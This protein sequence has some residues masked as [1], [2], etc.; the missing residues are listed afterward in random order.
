MKDTIARS[1]EIIE[2]H[3]RDKLRS[4]DIANSVFVSKYHYQRMF[5]EIMGDSVME[6]VKKRKLSLAGRELIKTDTAILDIAL[7]FGYGSHESFT[8]SFKAYM[9]VTP[10]AYRKY[11]P[12]PIFQKQL[13]RECTNM[14]DRYGK[15]T[16]EIVRDLNGLITQIRQTSDFAL[17]NSP[18]CCVVFWE[19]VVKR[20]NSFADGLNNKLSQ[21][22]AMSRNPDEITKRF[23]MIKIIEDTVFNTNLLAFTVGLYVSRS[24]PENFKIQEPICN[25]FSGLAENSKSKIN[26]IT[27]VFN[28][29]ATLIFEDIKKLTLEKRT[30]AVHVGMN[31]LESLTGYGYIKD[32]VSAIVDELSC[33]S[34]E[35][36]S[37]AYL[38][39]LI[40]RLD[41][42][43]FAASIDIT[44]NPADS[45]MLK[46]LNTFLNCLIETKSIFEDIPMLRETMPGQ[47][48]VEKCFEDIAYQGNILLFYI[49][50]EQEKLCKLLTEDHKARFSAI[51]EKMKVFI[52]IAIESE[53]TYDC[54]GAYSHLV[55]AL[56]EILDLMN[57]EAKALTDK[58]GAIAFIAAEIEK[59]RAKLFFL[60]SQ[61]TKKCADSANELTKRFAANL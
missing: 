10:R 37:P 7:K 58:G 45:A 36:I 1:L 54:N 5:H 22:T 31:A 34:Y 9:G 8:R 24:T 4:D 23:E 52:H 16:D 56:T 25:K 29:L 44:R 14:N 46:E 59:L 60:F 20:A 33:L 27:E 43:A 12:F 48:N 21:I 35:E 53:V 41:I 13:V 47:C 39:G 40:F 26:H 50:G 55:T 30:T 61:G 6:Y 11:G 57:F 49:K 18:M 28:E 17:K 3:I 51:T 38:E 42:I 15:I 2:A 32:E 19:T